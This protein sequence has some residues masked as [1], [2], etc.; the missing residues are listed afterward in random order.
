MYSV[1]GT[2]E[3]F[4]KIVLTV[5]D[6]YPM[7]KGSKTYT[8]Y[9]PDE[10]FI[11]YRMSNPQSLKWKMGHIHSHNTMK[12]FFSGTD[13]SELN[14]NSEFHNYYLSLIVNNCGE[15]TAKVAFRGSMNGFT[16]KNE[17]G[18]E[19]I[20]NL[21]NDR[22]I[23]FTFDC[24]IRPE[25]PETV[26]EE[27]FADRVAHIIKKAAS[28]VKV[29]KKAVDN[30]FKQK[31]FYTSPGFN[32]PNPIISSFPG[33]QD[34]L[35]MDSTEDFTRFVLR[36]GNES[37]EKDSFESAL[38]DLHV[39]QIPK[40]QFSSSVMDLYPSLYE[41]Y[42]DAFGS[43]DMEQFVGITEDVINLLEEWSEIYPF[44]EP[45]TTSLNMMLNRIEAKV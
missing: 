32:D 41:K 4:D 21:T 30:T 17:S 7:D 38:E 20:L 18:G 27:S 8:E 6:I 34:E 10:D 19:W 39:S 24:D 45:I 25:K 43:N 13:M 40:Q 2:I 1:E 44:I 12:T 42:F 15:M 9:E 23:L 28:K 35:E 37:V 33:R 11:G 22:E 31:P 36:L 29:Y 3:E 5:Q 16:C 26:V 14:D